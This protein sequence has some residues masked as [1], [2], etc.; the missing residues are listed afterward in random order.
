MMYLC[1]HGSGI[2][3]T[4]IHPNSLPGRLLGC[5]PCQ[6]LTT[7]FTT[8]LA[9]SFFSTQ[10]PDVYGILKKTQTQSL[11]LGRVELRLA[12]WQKLRKDSGTMITRFGRFNGASIK[13]QYTDFPP[14]TTPSRTH[15]CLS[16]QGISFR[17]RDVLAG[18]NGLFDGF[19]ICRHLSSFIGL[20]FRI[21]GDF[22]KATPTPTQQAWNVEWKRQPWFGVWLSK[23]KTFDV[24][25]QVRFRAASRPVSTS[26]H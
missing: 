19:G 8:S 3:Y 5:I 21:G 14:L 16:G 6:P 18:S 13:F 4:A 22:F 1:A 23:Y 26:S 17:G 15:P 24:E 12:L 11:Q 9:V 2:G 10:L 25:D 20:P 7:L